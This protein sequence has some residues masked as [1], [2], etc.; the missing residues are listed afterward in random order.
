MLVY[1]NLAPTGV[2]IASD[3][4]HAYISLP[5]V[6]PAGVMDLFAA[7]T[8]LRCAVN[9]AEDPGEE[10]DRAYAVACIECALARAADHPLRDHLRG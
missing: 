5:F 7:V 1:R 4:R 6:S 3:L 2:A 10:F 8:R 9:A